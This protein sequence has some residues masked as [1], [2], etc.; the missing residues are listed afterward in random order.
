MVVDKVKTARYYNL[1]SR[2][3]LCD[4]G[5]CKL[6]RIK[7][8]DAYPE[9]SNWLTQFGVDIRKPFEAMWLAPDKNGIVNYIGVQYIVLGTCPE[10]YECTIGNITIRVAPSHPTPEGIEGDFFVLEAYPMYLSIDNC[11]YEDEFD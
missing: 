9:L 10:K 8:A 5:F 3:S 6:Y 11:I 1:L 4:C 7:A 2:K